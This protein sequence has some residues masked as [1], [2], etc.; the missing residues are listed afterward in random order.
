[1][2]GHSLNYL[3]DMENAVIVDVEPTPTHISKEVEATA[4]MIERTSK[5]FDLNPKHI[6]G[7]VAY[8]T[9]KL[10]GWLVGRGTESHVP[11]TSGGNS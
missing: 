8:G 10:L 7:D 9:G 6:A 4:T 5:T 3:I 1:M 2:F 11:V